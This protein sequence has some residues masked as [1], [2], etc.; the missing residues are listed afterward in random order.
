MSIDASNHR[1]PLLVLI[2]QALE[3]RFLAVSFVPLRQILDFVKWRMWNL[4]SQQC[5]EGLA[6]CVVILSLYANKIESRKGVYI[7]AIRILRIVRMILLSR[8]IWILWTIPV[9]F[10]GIGDEFQYS[11]SPW[12]SR[13][14][15]QIRL[16]ESVCPD[17]MEL[18]N[19]ML[20]AMRGR[21]RLYIQDLR[22][23]IF[24]C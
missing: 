23:R 16:I 6:G 21:K 20:I 1:C 5:K 10:H 7:I 2:R 14:L 24:V 4:S 18:R 22:I 13:S 17:V 15:P 19:H 8:L 9:A 12:N 11:P 3:P